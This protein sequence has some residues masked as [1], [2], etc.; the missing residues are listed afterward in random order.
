[1]YSYQGVAV[2]VGAAPTPSTLLMFT[3][4]DGIEWRLVS[5]G[6][7][8]VQDCSGVSLNP[9][10]RRWLYWIKSNYLMWVRSF[11]YAEFGLDTP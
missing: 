6:S 3:S 10:R 8:P 7:G 1:M 11:R 2:G 5:P 4:A 9:F